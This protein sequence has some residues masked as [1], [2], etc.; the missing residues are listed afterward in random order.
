MNKTVIK[1]TI[2]KENTWSFNELRDSLVCN[3]SINAWYIKNWKDFVYNPENLEKQEPWAED[4]TWRKVKS[5]R[6]TK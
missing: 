5:Y 3:E 2:A 6:N 4:E 1:Q